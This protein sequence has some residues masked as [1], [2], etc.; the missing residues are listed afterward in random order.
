MFRLINTLLDRCLFTIFFILGVQLPEFIQQYSQQISGHLAE[1]KRHLSQ[2]QTLADRHYQGNLNALIDAYQKNADPVIVD[3]AKIVKQLVVRIDYLHH[4]L[5]Q[6][7]DASYWQQIKTLIIDSDLATIEHTMKLFKLAIPLELHALA[8]GAI[9]ALVFITLKF[10]LVEL[11]NRLFY[12]KR[13]QV[14]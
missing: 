2:F 3:T 4:H 12:S 6:L 5:A 14:V 11:L 1:A 7:L 13:T 8:T 10:M 9:C